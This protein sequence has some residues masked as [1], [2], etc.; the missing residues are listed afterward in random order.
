MRISIFLFALAVGGM[1]EAGAARTRSLFTPA[2]ERRVLEG[3][4]EACNNTWCEGD[5]GYDFKK[6][7]CENKTCTLDLDMLTYTKYD[8]NGHPDL[9][10]GKHHP[11]TCTFAPVRRLRDV[12]SP[13]RIYVSNKYFVSLAT[14]IDQNA[15]KIYN[16][17]APVEAPDTAVPANPE[18]IGPIA[19]IPPIPLPVESGDKPPPGPF[20]IFE[21]VFPVQQ[22]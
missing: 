20:G 1:A 18:S 9:Q 22:P 7:H 10:S 13:Y 8:A 2:Q 19:P 5:I 6:F 3:I 11:V 17:D 14:C 4:Q 12:L 21:T 15:S 16:E